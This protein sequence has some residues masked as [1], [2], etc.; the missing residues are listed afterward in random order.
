[1]RVCDFC[2]YNTYEDGECSYKEFDAKHNCKNFIFVV[3]SNVPYEVIS[4]LS[5][6]DMFYECVREAMELVFNSVIN[7]R[8]LLFMIDLNN[9]VITIVDKLHDIVY[10][11]FY[12]SEVS[13]GSDYVA[14]KAEEFKIF[15]SIL[16]VLDADDVIC[17]L[18]FDG[19]EL[20]EDYIYLGRDIGL[21]KKRFG[22]P[23]RFKISYE[24][25]PKKYSEE[26]T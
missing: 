9:Y 26:D 13:F 2:L 14:F 12:F 20:N 3:A 5:D 22:R 6:L 24:K 8:F 19:L 1:M 4:A 7:S 21:E 23:G 11:Q 18:V 10:D 15:S 17:Q 16:D 25:F